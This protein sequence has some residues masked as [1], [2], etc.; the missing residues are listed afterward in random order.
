[1]WSSA[2]ACMISP[3]VVCP[4]SI[5]GGP[6]VCPAWVAAR[7]PCPRRSLM[8]LPRGERRRLPVTHPT[9]QHPVPEAVA[10]FDDADSLYAAIAELETNGFNR[11]EISLLADEAAVE[12]KLGDRVWRAEELEDEPEAPRATYTSPASI[13]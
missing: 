4:V 11:S 12:E 1:M 8:S 6:A 9:H 5:A 2:S 7:N 3:A 10:V 13:G